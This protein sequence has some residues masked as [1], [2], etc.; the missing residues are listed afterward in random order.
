MKIFILFIVSLTVYGCAT[1]GPTIVIETDEPAE[2]FVVL[3]K[4]DKSYLFKIGH[5]ASR[6]TEVDHVIVAESGKEVDC[7]LM[8]GGTNGNV[9]ILHP[10]LTG[11]GGVKNYIKDGVR[12][13]YYDKT[14]LDILDEKKAK[15]DSGYWDKYKWPDSEFVNSV[16]GECLG[17][18]DQY[19]K[20]Y[21]SAVDQL[22]FASFKDKYYQPILECRRKEKKFYSDSRIRDGIREKYVDPETRLKKWWKKKEKVANEYK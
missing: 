1:V 21:L 2:D 17:A 15:F 10:T 3:C 16:R 7:G 22:D 20:Y 6:Y 18:F 14:K 19:F 5:N 11:S 12:H 8:V 9:T 13:I 4:K